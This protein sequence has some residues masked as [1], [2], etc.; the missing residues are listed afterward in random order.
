MK[1]ILINSMSIC[2]TA[3]VMFDK[4]ESLYYRDVKYIYL[5]HWAIN[6]K[7]NF[8][9]RGDAWL[10][11]GLAKVLKDEAQNRIVKVKIL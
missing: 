9:E 10:L 8:G 7:K 2:N 4:N 6:G 1:S 3:T 11:A 5:K